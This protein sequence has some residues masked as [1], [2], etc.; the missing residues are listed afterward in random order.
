MAKSIDRSQ[1]RQSTALVFLLIVVHMPLIVN[2]GLFAD[3]W[4]LFDVGSS[5]AKLDFLL[6]LAGHPILFAY[7]WLANVS[8]DPINF[9]KIMALVGIGV[10][11]LSLKSFLIRLRLFSEFEAF[12]FSFLVWSYA[13]FHSWA[14][15]NTETYVFDFGLLCFGLNALSILIQ[16]KNTRIELRLICYIAFFSASH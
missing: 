14:T 11:A 2:N 9:V 3:D 13:G 15:K 4:L 6:N 5:K 8:G 16:S 12:V 1:L 7:C 10:G